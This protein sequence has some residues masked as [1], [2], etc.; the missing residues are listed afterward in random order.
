M[1]VRAVAT[2]RVQLV[3]GFYSG[4]TSHPPA[5]ATAC[6]PSGGWDAGVARAQVN[7]IWV[8]GGTAHKMERAG[9]TGGRA[10]D[11]GARTSWTR[12]AA[13]GQCAGGAGLTR[14]GCTHTHCVPNEKITQLRAIAAPPSAS[15]GRRATR[16]C[17]SAQCARKDKLTKKRCGCQYVCVCVCCARAPLPCALCATICTTIVDQLG[18]HTGHGASANAKWLLLRAFPRSREAANIENRSAG[19]SANPESQGSS[20]G[21]KGGYAEAKVQ[22]AVGAQANKRC[23]WLCA[24]KQQPGEATI[25]SLVV[26]V[27]QEINRF[28][29]LCLLSGRPFGLHHAHWVH[30]VRPRRAKANRMR[31][32]FADRIGAAIPSVASVELRSAIVLF[33]CTI[34]HTPRLASEL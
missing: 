23:Q 5:R 28:V 34:Q 26:V 33:S 4:L 10:R 6:G 32:D 12:P 25:G 11:N 13:V 30:F 17:A 18:A 14:V 7:R 19:L 31:L 27:H 8:A 21:S 29:C 1:M 16:H 20:H 22:N 9:R 15:A 24:H 3:I 2:C